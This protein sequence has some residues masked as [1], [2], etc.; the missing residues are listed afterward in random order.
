LGNLEILRG[1]SGSGKSGRFTGVSGNGF[2]KTG[3]DSGPDWGVIRYSDIAM[4]FLVCPGTGPDNIRSAV[5]SFPSPSI[6]SR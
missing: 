4:V 6:H 1:F 5:K 3:A 2:S